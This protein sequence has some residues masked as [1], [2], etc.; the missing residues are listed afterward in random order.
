MNNKLKYSRQSKG[1]ELE[2]SKIT[3]MSIDDSPKESE[4]HTVLDISLKGY[5]KTEGVFS[6]S[7]ICVISG[8]EKREKDFLKEL[9]KNNNIRSLRITFLS[10]ENQGLQPYQMQEKWQEIQADKYFDFGGVR[11]QLDKI[12]KVYLLSDV[13]EFYEQLKNIKEKDNEVFGQ[14]IISNPC[15]EI[16][17]YYCYK[18]APCIDFETIILMT[19]AQRSQAI[20]SLGNKIIDG[21]LNCFY[22]FENMRVGIEN[23]ISTYAEDE[24]HIPTLFSTQMH[25]MAQ[26]LI[27]TMN[28]NENEFD[29]F[30]KQKREWR[31]KMKLI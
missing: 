15:F 12:D 9:I 8:G 21:G 28:N 3:S 29:N 26:V 25:K 7:I 5:E 18:C 24:N 22:S 27:Q 19:E 10:K 6:C 17:L 13:D 23:S 1:F 30:L 16:W 2:E 4:S 11:F 20:K 31:D 14:W